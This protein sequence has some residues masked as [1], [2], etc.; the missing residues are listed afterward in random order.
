MTERQTE[1]KLNS[2]QYQRQLAENEPWVPLAFFDE[3]RPESQE[4]VPSAPHPAPP[5]PPRESG[6]CAGA[7]LSGWGVG[8]VLLPQI[9][10]F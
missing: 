7:V 4:A 2:H 1:F 9:D 5:L 10:M 6:L 3:H 8:G